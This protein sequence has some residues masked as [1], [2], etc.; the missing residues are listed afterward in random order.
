MAEDPS[1]R[2]T[3]P[4]TE[5]PRGLRNDPELLQE[6]AFQEER[7]GLCK[8]VFLA[9]QHLGFPKATCHGSGGR[10]PS[11]AKAALLE[12]STRFS[13]HGTSRLPRRDHENPSVNS[14]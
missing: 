5:R 2:D 10:K 9:H 3:A 14:S 7:L 12:K 1:T 8:D 13:C 4:A 11:L 6:M